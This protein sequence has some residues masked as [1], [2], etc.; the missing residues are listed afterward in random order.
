MTG[1]LDPALD[2]VAE[3]RKA[4]ALL[5]NGQTK[6]TA[7][8]DELAATV[9]R[10]AAD[11]LAAAGDHDRLNQLADMLGA[12]QDVDQAGGGAGP[13]WN[14]NTM[15]ADKAARA[16][17]E[18]IEWVD[19]W[20][21]PLQPRAAAQWDNQPCWWAWCWYAH[22]EAVHYVSAL[23]GMWKQA[24]TGKTAG[25]PRVAEWWHRWLPD[26]RDHL[27]RILGDCLNGEHTTPTTP[28]QITP[29]QADERTAHITADINRRPTE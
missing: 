12:L 17:A 15:P 5:M 3:V 24:Y 11:R 16:W 25:A 21:L 19:G 6:T 13:A 9:D 10:L 27:R 23:Y 14:W 8:L 26:T 29:D 20:L 28:S 22:P 2:P 7:R 18:L 1:P 4:V